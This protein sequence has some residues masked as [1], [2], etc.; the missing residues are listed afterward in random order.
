MK[1]SSLPAITNVGVFTL[2]KE[3]GQL[4]CQLQDLGPILG[5]FITTWYSWR[6]GFAMEVLII[7]F[8]LI[9]SRKLIKIN[10]ILTWKDL[11]IWGALLSV[12]GIFLLV[13]GILELNNLKRWD[14]AIFTIILAMFILI[15]FYWW[16]KKK[17]NQ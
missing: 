8:M 11:V 17:I 10:P 5:G 13:L 15:T 12:S 7:V 6:Y 9:Y 3:S 4:L 14:L 2:F 16:Q 1:T